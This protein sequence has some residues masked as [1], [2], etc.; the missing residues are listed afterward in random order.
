MSEQVIEATEETGTEH[1]QPAAAGREG[2]RP[3]ADWPLQIGKVR[4]LLLCW[5]RRLH[6]LHK[7]LGDEV[8]RLATALRFDPE[9]HIVNL[10]MEK[11]DLIDAHHLRQIGFATFA[12]SAL[13][14]TEGIGLMKGKAWAEYLTLS[15]T[16]IFL[17]WELYELARHATWLRL[18]LLVANLVVLAY[19][20]WLLKRKK[21][22]DQAVLAGFARV[23][24]FFR[25]P[26]IFSPGKSLGKL[27]QEPSRHNTMGWGYRELAYPT[28][29]GFFH[30]TYRNLQLLS[31]LIFPLVSGEA[32]H[33]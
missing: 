14:L 28:K 6:L 3:A 18:G 9:G 12:Y 33:R 10:M 17:P 2:S 22:V 11:V 29:C 8:M 16:I 5:H 13:A 27:E 1:H 25:L 20:L 19:L 21:K 31:G 4:L 30:R 24:P 23:S 7:D 26:D 32:P 15:L